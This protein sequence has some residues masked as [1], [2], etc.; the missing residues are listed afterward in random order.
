MS[1]KSY[2]NWPFLEPKHR[3]LAETLDT[4]AAENIDSNRTQDQMSMTNA[5]SWYKS[6]LRVAG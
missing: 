2:L 3:E 4:W 1:D 6:W 5:K